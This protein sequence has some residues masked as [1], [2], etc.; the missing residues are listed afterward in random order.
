M[1]NF[2]KKEG[3][4]YDVLKI[5]IVVDR[6]TA[7]LFKTQEC[8]D[9]C[10]NFFNV[11]FCHIN[12]FDLNYGYKVINGYDNFKYKISRFKNEEIVNLSAFCSS[13]KARFSISNN[14]FNNKE[15]LLSYINVTI[16][17][18]RSFLHSQSLL[19]LMNGVNDLL[20]IDYAYGMKISDDFD[21]DLEKRI[22]KSFLG[23]S[24]SL[25]I[26]D[27][28]INFEKRKIEFKNGYVKNIYQFN[29]LN[30]FQLKSSLVSQNIQNGLGILSKFSSKISCWIL[31]DDDFKKGEFKL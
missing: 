14:I 30:E 31:N 28:D 21:F 3:K 5:Y 9:K 29:F 23:N 27:D 1:F 16:V 8:I 20:E 2:L 24:V 15:L 4:E 22:S 25:S 6:E 11:N 12:M 10:F 26:T 19:D 13:S 7:K 18:D 17:L